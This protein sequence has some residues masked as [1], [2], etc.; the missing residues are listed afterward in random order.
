MQ[1]S[2]FIIGFLL[3]ALI[4]AGLFIFWRAPQPA[5]PAT[6]VDLGTLPEEEM[7]EPT[8]VE[9]TFPIEEVLILNTIE[10]DAAHELKLVLRDFSD[11]SMGYLYLQIT[12]DQGEILE[13]FFVDGNANPFSGDGETPG[14]FERTEVARSWAETDIVLTQQYDEYFKSETYRV[15]TKNLGEKRLGLNFQISPEFEILQFQ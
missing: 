12:N 14:D 11:D 13:D 3:A 9:S 10:L 15:A 2:S 6:V 7:P 8:V 5:A 4:A 1:K